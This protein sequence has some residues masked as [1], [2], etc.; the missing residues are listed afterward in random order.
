MPIQGPLSDEHELS[1]GNE[2]DQPST[3]YRAELVSTGT[4]SESDAAYLAHYA[5]FLLCVGIPR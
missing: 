1:P 5:L 3:A 2:A 4:G